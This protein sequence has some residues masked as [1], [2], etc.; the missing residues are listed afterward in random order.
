V[1][2]R[3]EWS[4]TGTFAAGLESISVIRATQQAVRKQ[5]SKQLLTDTVRSDKQVRL[6]QSSSLNR[7]TKHLA[8]IAVTSKFR[9]DGHNF[10]NR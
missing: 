10:R 1:I 5:A 7:A 3:H 8:L 6:R 2:A 9:P 4:A